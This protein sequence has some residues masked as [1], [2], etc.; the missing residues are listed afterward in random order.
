MDLKSVAKNL[1]SKIAN[2]SK[3]A[4][5]AYKE[6]ATP[7]EFPR[8]DLPTLVNGTQYC[9]VRLKKTDDMLFS[10]TLQ[11]NYQKK[12]KWPKG[13]FVN[14]NPK[15]ASETNEKNFIGYVQPQYCKKLYDKLQEKKFVY[16]HGSVKKQKGDYLIY[17]YFENE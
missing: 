15:G 1:G 10:V 2:T 13:K 8:T 9:K 6:Y 17:L 4:L 11:N 16:V 12:Q 5:A 14:V 3:K 7:Y